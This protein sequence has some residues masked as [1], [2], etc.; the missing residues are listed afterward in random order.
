[1]IALGAINRDGAADVARS[2][3][4]LAVRTGAAKPDIGSVEALR[5][6]LLQARSIAYSDGPSGAYVADLL[7]KLGIAAAVAAKVKLPAGCGRGIGAAGVSSR[8]P[9]AQAARAFLAF[10]RGAQAKQLMRAKGL[11]PA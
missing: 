11:D 8:A 10:M 6:V 7:A 5:R 2:T 1:L 4:G 3:I 9:D